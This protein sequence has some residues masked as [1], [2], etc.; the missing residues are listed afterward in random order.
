MA[1]GQR[2][3]ASSMPSGARRGSVRRLNGAMPSSPR[4]NS[5]KNDTGAPP[6]RPGSALLSLVAAALGIGLLVVVP[7]GSYSAC[8]G[9]AACYPEL[10]F[11]FLAVLLAAMLAY[12]ARRISHDM[13][14]HSAAVRSFR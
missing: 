1:P 14:A 12:A 9:G 7:I 10:V 4:M 3:I 6:R 8:G 11:I 2:N 5:R 13:V